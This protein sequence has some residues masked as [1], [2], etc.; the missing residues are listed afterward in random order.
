MN[1]KYVF[2]GSTLSIECAKARVGYETSRIDSGVI[3][4]YISYDDRSEYIDDEESGD[5]AEEV[6][7]NKVDDSG[8]D[9]EKIMRDSTGRRMSKE[10]KEH[11]S[12]STKENVKG[13]D[14]LSDIIDHKNAVKGSTVKGSEAKKR[15][16]ETESIR[17]VAVQQ[18]QG[19]LDCGAVA[20]A[21]ALIDL[22]IVAPDDFEVTRDKFKFDSPDGGQYVH[23]DD[24]RGQLKEFNVGLVV[25]EYIQELNRYKVFKNPIKEG[26]GIVKLRLKDKHFDRISDKGY[27]IKIEID[28][29]IEI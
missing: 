14:Q 18:T 1:G 24:L 20:I 27:P 3:R 23:S 21:E 7:D 15:E 22:G 25:Y 28:E 4:T 8:I 26:C 9:N 16:C 13:K 17:V 19:E 11:G 5:E 6:S 29:V 12:T 10:V 2:E